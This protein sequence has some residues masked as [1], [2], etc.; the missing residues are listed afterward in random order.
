MT[1][2]DGTRH[3]NE[4]KFCN[5]LGVDESG[6]PSVR[7][8]TGT[9]NCEGVVGVYTGYMQAKRIPTVESRITVYLV[10]RVGLSDF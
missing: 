9:T 5:A 6:M 1:C 10:R 4:I 2:D 8:S 3:D 7:G